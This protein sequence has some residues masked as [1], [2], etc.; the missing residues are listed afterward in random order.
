[1]KWGPKKDRKE[2]L[3]AFKKAMTNVFD[4]LKAN[5]KPHQ[6]V[7]IRSTPYG[8]GKCSQYKAPSDTVI[9]PTGAEGE[10]EWDMFESFDAVWKEWVESEKDPRFQFFDVSAMS[11]M[12]GDAH[13]RPD[14]DCLHT[15]IP[16]PVDDWNKLLY[17]EITKHFIDQLQ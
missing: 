7:W 4:Y 8:H 12:R 9:T 10:Y 11:N 2:L 3:A 14:S 17:H 6:R 15:C 1:L 5:V 13:S 16:G